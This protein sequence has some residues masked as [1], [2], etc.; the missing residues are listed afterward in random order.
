[1]FLFQLVEKLEKIGELEAEVSEKDMKIDDV[2]EELE[3][4]HM[5]IKAKDDEIENLTQGLIK[6]SYFYCD[7]NVLLKYSFDTNLWH[8]NCCDKDRLHFIFIVTYEKKS[9]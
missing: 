8:K 7:S 6:V 9:L 3:T 2:M 1:M 5:E 4:R